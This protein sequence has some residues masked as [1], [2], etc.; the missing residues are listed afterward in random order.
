ME[1]PRLEGRL[2]IVAGIVAA[3]VALGLEGYLYANRERILA[4]YRERARGP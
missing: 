2:S 4:V 1:A 3:V